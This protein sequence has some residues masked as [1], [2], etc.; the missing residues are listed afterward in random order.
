MAKTKTIFYCTNCGHESP[1][2]VGR[3]PGCGE[4]NT[5]EEQPVVK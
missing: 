1:K 2:W 4:W 5:M 3:C